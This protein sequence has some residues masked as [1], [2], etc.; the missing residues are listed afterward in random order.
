M[1]KESKYIREYRRS[2]FLMGIIY[3]YHNGEYTTY[4]Y[5]ITDLIIITGH[6]VRNTSIVIS[7]TPTLLSSE[8]P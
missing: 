8:P 1:S 7:S 5:N 6:F 3:S 2:I 4:Q